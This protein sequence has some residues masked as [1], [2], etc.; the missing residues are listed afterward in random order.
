MIKRFLIGAL[1]FSGTQTVALETNAPFDSI[2]GGTLS[3]DQWLGQPVLVVNTASQCVFTRQY[4]GLQDLY[5]A[6]RAQGLIVV[7]VPSDDFNQELATD[8]E[9]KD[10]CELMYGLDLPMT[11]ITHVK[12]VDAHPFYASLKA[13][14]GFTRRWNFNKV[15][16][17][18]SGAVVATFGSNTPPQSPA[19]TRLIDGMLIND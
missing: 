19:I 18:E 11:V 5:D 16:I 2:D 6:C 17:D 12:G 4:R 9:V 14:T 8:A 3:I 7:A 15:H 13:E 1:I 10:F